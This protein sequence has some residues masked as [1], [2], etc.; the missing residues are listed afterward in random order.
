M[1]RVLARATVC[2]VG[3]Y[4]RRDSV[5]ILLIVLL[6]RDASWDEDDIS[7]VYATTTYLPG[8][9][10]SSCVELP[11]SVLGLQITSRGTVAAIESGLACFG[12]SFMRQW[13]E[14]PDPWKMS[15]RAAR[16]PASDLRNR[17]DVHFSRCGA[18]LA[19][20]RCPALPAAVRD[21]D[22]QTSYRYSS[23]ARVEIQVSLA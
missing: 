14:I 13:L 21:R 12:R 16:M 2:I 22:A 17:L 10:Y 19:N 18:A 23:K 7:I 4:C 3:D 8:S 20:I 1:S 11:S 5:A 9:A 15:R 6:L